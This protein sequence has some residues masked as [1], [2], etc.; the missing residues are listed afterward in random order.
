[1]GAATGQVHPDTA[2]VAN[3][4]GPDPQKLQPDGAALCPGKFRPFQHQASHRLHQ[5]VCQ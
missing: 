5:D 4:N 2:C 1:M 3:D